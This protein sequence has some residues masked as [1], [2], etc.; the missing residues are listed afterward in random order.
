MLGAQ[1]RL[2]G[3][4]RNRRQVTGVHLLEVLLIEALGK[5]LCLGEETTT[6]DDI[7]LLQLTECTEAVVGACLLYTSDAADE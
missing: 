6:L 7:L 2:G 4:E 3:K 5:H 1:M